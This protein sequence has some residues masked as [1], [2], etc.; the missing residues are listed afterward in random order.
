MELPKFDPEPSGEFAFKILAETNVKGILI[1]RLSVWAWI[2][3][4]AG[5]AFTKDIDIAITQKDQPAIVSY[6]TT[7]GFQIRE[8]SIGGINVTEVKNNLRVDFIHRNSA[9]YGDLSKLF[10]EAIEEALRN[11]ITVNFGAASLILVP[12]EYLISMKIGTAERKDEE[13]ARRLL[14]SV[15]SVD[16]N[17]LRKIVSIHLGPLGKSKLEN[18][19]REAGHP[20]ARPRGKYVS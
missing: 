16:V 20:Q 15:E 19:L 5:H 3:D 14:E 8:L 13:D 10:E 7:R 2:E 6:L 4:P 18:I 1:G 12:V 11:N 17:K 9:E